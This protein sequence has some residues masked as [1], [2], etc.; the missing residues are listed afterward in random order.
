MLSL[1]RLD[2]SP[3]RAAKLRSILHY[4][5][6]PIDARSVTDSIEEQEG[7]KRPHHADALVAR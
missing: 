4:S 7:L 3:A 6:L 5:G 1:I 2:C